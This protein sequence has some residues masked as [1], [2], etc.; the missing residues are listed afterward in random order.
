MPSVPF[1]ADVQDTINTRS[2]GGT[3]VAPETTPAV[4]RT[5]QPGTES[6]VT[7]IMAG[8]EPPA[9]NPK[10]RLSTTAAELQAERDGLLP[11]WVR[12]P[13]QGVEFYTGFS[14]SYLYALAGEGKCR[15]VS[16]RSPGQIKGVRL[17][18]LGSLLDF[19]AKCETSANAEMEGAK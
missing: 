13:R 2:N 10:R 9:P 3:I 19:I 18:H 15:S 16:I 12:S 5:P 4:R 6:L 11:V 8:H 17:F 14:R 1:A 7:G